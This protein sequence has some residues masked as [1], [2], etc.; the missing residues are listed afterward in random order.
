[1]S[2]VREFVP[3]PSLPAHA[4]WHG[5]DLELPELHVLAVIRLGCHYYVACSCREWVSESQDTIQQ[6]Q[7]IDCCPFEELQME[8]RRNLEAYRRAAIAEAHLSRVFPV[9]GGV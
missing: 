6:A 1:M 8:G 4:Q 5:D 7:S 9:R 3:A 2:D